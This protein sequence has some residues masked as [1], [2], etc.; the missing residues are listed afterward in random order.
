MSPNDTAE[1]IRLTGLSL[2]FHA[3]TPDQRIALDDLSLTLRKGDFAVV[4]GSNG[5]GKSTML[6]AIAGSLRPDR[7]T[8]AIG[9]VDV[10]GSPVHRRAR[11]IGRIF[12]DPMLGTA[13]AL[14]IEENL[15]LA[16]KRGRRRRLGLALNRTNRGEFAAMLAPFGLGLENRMG[17]AAGLLSG[18][19]RQVLAL[20]MASLE[21]PRILL[22]DEHTAALDPG[23]AEV[24]MNA[25]RRIVEDAGLTTLMIT[26]NMAQAVGYGNRL[27]AMDAGR[28]KLDISGDDKDGLTVDD[29]IK[30]FG[31]NSDRTLLQA[32][33]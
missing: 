6:N 21:K 11:F 1:A 25:T 7:G 10:T 15:A 32:Q 3:G 28:I 4:I 17:I 12:Q 18:G 22:L 14:S 16:S 2:V 27:L 29:L 23:T 19:Q 20:L 5:A 26:H 33:G 24:V 30:R 31:G 13:P 9:G 8:I